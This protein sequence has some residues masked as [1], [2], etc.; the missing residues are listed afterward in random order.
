MEGGAGKARYMEV[1]SSGCTRCSEAGERED[2]EREGEGV[3]GG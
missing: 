2:V 1:E 3:E